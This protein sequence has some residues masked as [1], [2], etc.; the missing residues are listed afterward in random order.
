[1]VKPR[2]NGCHPNSRISLK[3][4]FFLWGTSSSPRTV[5]R[6]SENNLYGVFDGHGGPRAAD[7][8]AEDI[9]RRIA[10]RMQQGQGVVGAA[11]G[12]SLFQEVFQQVLRAPL[13][14]PPAGASVT[15]PPPHS[16][17][18]TGLDPA[19]APRQKCSAS[20]A[21]SETLFRL[22]ATGGKSVA[23]ASA[24]WTQASDGSAIPFSHTRHAGS[25]GRAVLCSHT[26]RISSRRRM[27]RSASRPTPTSGR[28]G[29][30]PAW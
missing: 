9:P 7:F 24:Q 11:Q 19:V 17:R 4:A 27:M 12:L 16:L 26:R 23:G 14:A 29:L 1:M 10:A 30:L 2:L 13:T 6:N 5:S 3:L 18:P 21:C 20:A 8:A 25:D 22:P 15:S 28:M